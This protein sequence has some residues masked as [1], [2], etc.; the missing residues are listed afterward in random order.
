MVPFLIADH[1]VQYIH[2]Y[3]P[4]PPPHSQYIGI[5]DLHHF[6]TSSHFTFNTWVFLDPPLMRKYSSYTS[7]A[8]SRESSSASFNPDTAK[9]RRTLY[10]YR[11]KLG[12]QP[13]NITLRTLLFV[14]TK[15][16]LAKL[17]ICPIFTKN[18]THEYSIFKY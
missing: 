13:E 6:P 17:A 10:R 9:R 3:P 4:P 15:L 1:I 5:P 11:N 7:S 12:R 18:Y 14:G 16:I 2:T 8:A